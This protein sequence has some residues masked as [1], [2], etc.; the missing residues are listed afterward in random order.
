ME[1]LVVLDA[2]TIGE[3][4]IFDAFKSFGNL[5]VFATTNNA[6]RLQHIDN[7]SIIITNKVIIDKEIMDACPSLK[8]ICLTATGMNNVDLPYAKSKGIIV[9]NVAGYSTESVVQHTFATLLTLLQHTAYYSEYVFSKKYSNQNL[10]TH[11]GPGYMELNGRTWGIIGLGTIGRRVAEVASAFGCKVVYYSTSGSNHTSDYQE[12]TLDKLLKT[13]DIISI[14]S[15]LNEQT[16]GLIGIN[17]IRKMKPTA[18]LINVGRG[19]I[20]KENDLAQ[21][22][23]ENCIAGACIDVM[24]KEPLPLE[25]PLLDTSIQNKLVITPHV[26]WVSDKALKS[27]MEL[28]YKNVETFVAGK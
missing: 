19:G 12:V 15:P 25:S 24:Q 5:R 2:A 10:F 1:N 21:G 11:I 13:A 16:N 7:A 20:I 3:N 4:S 22:L 6:E 9:K 27:L 14:H 8:L 18:Y 23:Q 28:T 17:E 26:A